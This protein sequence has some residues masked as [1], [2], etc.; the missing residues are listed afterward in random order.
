MRTPAPERLARVFRALADETRLR[1]LRL[2]PNRPV[3]ADM[4]N[5]S[6]LVEHIGGSQPNMS[7][8]LHILKDAGLVQARKACGGVYYWRVP[9]AFR[10]VAVM[11]GQHASRP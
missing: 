1:I 10:E 6:E 2:L 7:R 11:L 5:V 8:H 9:Q 4:Y 3:C